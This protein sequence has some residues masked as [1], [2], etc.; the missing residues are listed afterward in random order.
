MRYILS[1]IF[2]IITTTSIAQNQNIADSLTSLY[3]NN[4][5]KDSDKLS[6]LHKISFNHSDP[7]KIIYFANELLK[8][9]EASKNDKY[10]YLS[11]VH[12]GN[13]FRL[14]GDYD[15]AFDYFFKALESAIKTDHKKRIGESN[16]RIAD[17]YA[18]IGDY[19]NAQF[20]YNKCIQQLNLHGDKLQLAIA[21]L[22]FGDNYLKQNKQDSALVNFENASQIFN[23]Q[24]YT[25]GQAYSI[26]NIG[27]VY[28]HQEKFDLAEEKLKE[29]INM[30][31]EL[32]DYYAISDYLN[33]IVDIYIEE[34]E[35]WLALEYANIAYNHASKM[36]YKEQ[37]KDASLRLS[38]IYETM[39]KS[40]EAFD[41]LKTYITYRD[42]LKN[43]SIIY[44][45]SELRREYELAQLKKK[46]SD[47]NVEGKDSEG[48]TEKT[49]YYALFL[50]VNNYKNNDEKLD[51]L[52]KP[53]QDAQQLHNTLTSYYNFDPEK[54]ILISDPSRADIINALE[55]LS[56]TINERDNLLIFYAGHGVWDEKL[57]IG[58]WLPSDAKSDSKANWISNS[59]IRDY[60]SGLKTKHTLLISDACFSGGIFKTRSIS[61]GI[62]EYGFTK[63]YKLPSRKAMTSG[64]LT[65]VPDDSKFMKYLIKHLNENKDDYLTARQLFARIE[66]AIINNTNN[67]PQYGI[68]QNAGDEGGEFIFIK[69]EKYS[70]N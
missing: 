20:F 26:G 53:I 69:K 36:G 25:A 58:Y 31:E 48:K 39:N 52:K 57:Q 21:L 46:A 43:E 15:V 13:G 63:L 67:V 64:T 28:A 51:D 9:S 10:I 29:A 65:T 12:L 60:I 45:M 33:H 32:G 40:G 41:Y 24:K 30:L 56:A 70:R 2:F 11:I 3:L 4:E 5:I 23:E 47:R 59:T 68:I 49:S 50:G 66:T 54:V 37:I 16:C 6:V 44:R 61:N 14:K 38:K 34:Q 22:N 62:D 17:T 7:E 55:A 8:V 1:A 27:L 35:V 18:V 19:K 42:S